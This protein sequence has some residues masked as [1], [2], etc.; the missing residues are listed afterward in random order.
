LQRTASLT[1]AAGKGKAT[2]T[3]ESK[4]RIGP[5]SLKLRLRKFKGLFSLTAKKRIVVSVAFTFA[6]TFAFAAIFWLKTKKYKPQ[7]KKEEEGGTVI[8]KT[9]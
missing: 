3:T 1:Y 5:A 8:R 4:K 9:K 6:F 2:F 7:S